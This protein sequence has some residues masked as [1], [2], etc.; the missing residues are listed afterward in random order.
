MI[1]RHAPTFEPTSSGWIETVH[2][3]AERH[4]ARR[5]TDDRRRW[6]APVD[7]APAARPSGGGPL[8]YCRGCRQSIDAMKP[9]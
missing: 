1:L 8:L 3:L 2:A 6:P 5:V 9:V 4:Q 7:P